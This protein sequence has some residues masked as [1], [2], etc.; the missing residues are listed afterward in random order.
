MQPLTEEFIEQCPVEHG[1]RI[2]G[3][4][5]TRI[6]VFVDAAFAFAVTML[7]ISIDQIPRSIPELLGI[8]KHIPAF[9]LSVAQ[10]VLIWHSHSVWSRRFGLEDTRT[11][12]LS[13]SLLAIVLIYVYPLKMMFEGLFA[14]LTLGYLPS[15]FK[16][17]SY[18]ELKQLFY[19][20]SIGFACISLIFM[21]LY[22]HAK[23]MATQL[24][25]SPQEIYQSETAIVVNQAMA[26]VCLAN[27]V[28]VYFTQGHWVPFTGFVYMLIWPLVARIER[29]RH[30]QWVASQATT[31]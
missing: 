7:V 20:F 23:K 4:A 16:L 11:V 13:V 9:L 30:R 2:R 31:G 12:V 1:F 22:Q 19:Y 3:L 6:E 10:L 5:M 8:S 29:R 28:L 27:M 18:E 17:S 24:R 25:L 14:W 15:Q 21:A 26:A